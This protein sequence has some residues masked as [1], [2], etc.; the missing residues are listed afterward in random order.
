MDDISIIY[1]HRMNGDLM[2]SDVAK[3][4]DANYFLEHQSGELILSEN[5]YRLRAIAYRVVSAEDELYR[6]LLLDG[7]NG[8][9]IILSTCD[10]NVHEKRD[11]LVLA[12]E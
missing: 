9:R 4:R 12:L 7:F 5:S 11:I 2:F 8:N 3:Y 1:G 10:R 6:N